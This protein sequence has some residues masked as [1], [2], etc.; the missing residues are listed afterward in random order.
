MINFLPCEIF[1]EVRQKEL[2]AQMSTPFHL[3]VD[4]DAVPARRQLART[5]SDRLG[6]SVGFQKSRWGGLPDGE[7]RRDV[8][9]QSGSS[10]PYPMCTAG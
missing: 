9:P 7:G 1:P 5:Q 8:L 2:E 6:A 4:V 3:P 10:A